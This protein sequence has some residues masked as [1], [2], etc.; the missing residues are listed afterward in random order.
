[1][2]QDRSWSWI[3]AGKAEG[4]MMNAETCKTARFCTT[5]TTESFNPGRIHRMKRT[6]F[7]LILHSTFC[8]LPLPTPAATNDLTTLLQRGLFEEEAN[9]NLDAAIAQYQSLA[10]RFDQDR[11]VAA[12]AVFRLGE[13]YRKLGRTNEAVVQY[14]RILTDFADQATLVTLSRQDLAAIGAKGAAS[15]IEEAAAGAADN[16]SL[17]GLIQ[18][19]AQA[20]VDAAAQKS[21]LDRFR[22]LSPAEQARVVEE[23]NYANPVLTKLIQD[24]ASE[25]QNLVNL[26]KSYTAD[27]IHIQTS[28]RVLE[29]IQAQI[30]DQVKAYLTA[31]EIRYEATL[32]KVKTLE[33]LLDRIQ[34]RQA[35]SGR[36]IESSG[37]DEDQEIRRIQSMV[38][39]SPDLI[40]VTSGNSAL[41]PLARA[42]GLGQ[43]RVAE[44]LLEHGAA[45]EAQPGNEFTPLIEAT[46]NGHKAMVELLLDHGANVNA[47]GRYGNTMSTPLL[48]AV[49]KGYEAVAELLLARLGPPR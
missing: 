41:T 13:C 11:Q 42:A 4:R 27:S 36:T 44:Y 47:R 29:T 5:M 37:T 43:L 31:R 2:D 40:N 34:S 48:I 35:N 18:D 12:T 14:N 26:S 49:S 22:K 25:Q 7:L 9:R 33:A 16:S 30:A 24:Y 38:Q 6:A 45:I 15:R 19:L 17:S 1:M 3:S 20:Q 10:T 8:L 39:N 21:E 32:Q 46:G 23:N 28:R